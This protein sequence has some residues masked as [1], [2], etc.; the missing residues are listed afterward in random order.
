[1]EIADRPSIVD[2]TSLAREYQKI[3][4][5]SHTMSVPGVAFDTQAAV[6]AGEQVLRE[7]GMNGD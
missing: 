7:L 5:T 4:Y 2:G 3:G 6:A 1:V